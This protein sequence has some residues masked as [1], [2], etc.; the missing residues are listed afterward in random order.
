MNI[1]LVNLFICSNKKTFNSFRRCG[2]PFSFSFFDFNKFQ[3][4]QRQRSMIL[5]LFVFILAISYNQ[6]NFCANASWNPNAITLTNSSVIGSF[7]NAFFVDTH[8]TL[9]VPHPQNGQII[10][11]RNGSLNPTTTISA[12]L[13]Y[14]HSLFVTDDE[15]IFIDSEYPN[16]RVDKWTSNGTRLPS[17]ISVCS[18]CSGLFVDSNDDLYCSQSRANQVVRRSL[19]NPSSP[20]MIVAGTG[21]WGST[22]STLS[23]PWG[24]FVTNQFDLYVADN[25]NDR[26]QLFR[27]GEL[28]ATTVA[29]NGANGTTIT[30]RRPTGVMLDGDGYLFIVDSWNNR[31]IGSGPWGFRCLVGCSGRGSSSNQLSSPETMN[32]D[33]D[34]N[35]L[36]LDSD[37]S[38]VQKFFLASNS[39]NCR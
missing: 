21:C 35:L 22:A 38:R 14:P 19:V 29:G 39:C 31:I 6:P 26:I 3:V 4:R 23:C 32:F 8:N 30:L 15:Q 25:A 20:T 33:L 16:S 34:G 5:I 28:N 1:F 2:Q 11:W 18:V 17:P 7:P 27:E 36:V 13:S 37:N 24:I 9:V 10:I 12:N